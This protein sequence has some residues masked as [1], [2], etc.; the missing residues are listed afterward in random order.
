MRHLEEHA[1]KA[2]GEALPRHLLTEAMDRFFE[3]ASLKP[4]TLESY[5]FTSN[6][7]AFLAIF[8][9]MRSHANSS[10]SS[11]RDSETDRRHGCNHSP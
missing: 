8:T 3:E 4:R 9:L 6:I 7:C 1:Q 10:R 5:K 2:R 11:F